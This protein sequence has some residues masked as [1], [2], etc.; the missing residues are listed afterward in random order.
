MGS[1]LL[2]FDVDEVMAEVESR[3]AEVVLMALTSVVEEADEVLLDWMV[4]ELL[5]E[6]GGGI[7]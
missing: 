7:W 2:I 6:P 4:L 3:V 1:V 5:I